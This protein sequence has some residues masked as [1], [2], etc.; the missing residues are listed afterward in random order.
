MPNLDTLKASN[1]QTPHV[2]VL[3][4][5]RHSLDPC[6]HVKYP[7]SEFL[8]TSSFVVRR[9]LLFPSMPLLSISSAETIAKCAS[10]PLRSNDVFI[11]SYPKSGTT[12]TQHIVLS[13]LRCHVAN[14]HARR[15]GARR[16]SS[17]TSAEGASL[18]NENTPVVGHYEYAVPNY[19]HVSEFAPFFEIDAHW[20]GNQLAKKVQERQELL[21][22][23]V[24]NTHLRFDML[25]SVNTSSTDCGARFICVIRS[26]LDVCVSFYH[27][28]VHQ[29]EGG[30]DGTFQEFFREWMDGDI[31]FGSW[32]HHILSIAQG[33]STTAGARSQPQQQQKQQ[34]DLDPTHSTCGRRHQVVL[35][36]GRQL[37]MVTYEEMLC[38][39]PTVV[40]EIQHFLGLHSISSQQ[41]QD[42]L[43]TFSFD[44]MKQ[45]LDRFQPQSVQWKGDFTFLRKGTV[46]DSKRMLSNVQKA[47][48]KKR[49]DDMTFHTHLT[50][51]LK[52]S[53]PQM[54]DMLTNLVR[55][56]SDAQVL[57][58]QCA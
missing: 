44:S 33:I 29:V 10:L 52:A 21:G 12:W 28:L 25:P 55:T 30:Y 43:P 24:F 16:C 37:L 27:H 15:P 8:T 56:S 48:L 7:Y 32:M 50:R 18:L 35:P 51:L 42:M 17:A 22:T 45:D 19:K 40:K 57:W 38:D 2:R 46:G 26:P 34:E 9:Q 3:V 5:S 49:L 1:R 53:H 41:L 14:T 13:L 23:R 4:P 31:A 36:D 58:H 47:E 11:C 54:Y 6:L 39:L 20:E